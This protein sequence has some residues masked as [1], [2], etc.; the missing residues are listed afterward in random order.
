MRHRLA[1][2]RPAVTFLVALLAG[3][4]ALGACG[5]DD[6][7][8][9]GGGGGGD[10]A[11]AKPQKLAITVSEQGKDQ[12][13]LTAPKSVK[14]GV[15]EISLQTPAGQRTT[16]D[17]Q[18]IRVE[19]NH[20][21]DEVLKFIS[22]EGAPTP[23]WLFAAGGVGQTKSGESGTATQ[24]LTPGKYFILDTGE[25]EGDN[26]KSYAETGATAELQVTGPAGAAKL[27]K[28]GA[29]VTAKDGKARGA[30][31][32]T[33]SGLTAGKTRIEFDNAGKELHHLIAFPFRKGA[34]LADV[35]KAF[36][37][38]RGESS[39]PPPLDFEAGAG[40]AVLE[41]GTKQVTTLELKRGKYAL[42]CF[43]SDRKGGKP[44]VAK[45]MLVETQ[46]E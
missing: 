12:F 17:A 23:P 43:I 46:V 26:V 22:E 15:V 42:V 3:A 9:G 30:Y 29:K 27:P 41:G 40:T 6:D 44:H 18:F 11:A 10:T 2:Q 13:T 19:G 8:N 7:D 31:T 5:D 32:F 36:M 25:P 14:A 1:R 24:E 34:T 33:A 38:E 20:T 28:A 4:L 37:E 45:G 16:H 35:K 39:G 21:I